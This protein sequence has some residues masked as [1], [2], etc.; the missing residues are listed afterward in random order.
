M[1]KTKSTIFPLQYRKNNGNIYIVD[2][3]SILSEII[4]K[5]PLRENAPQTE[6]EETVVDLESTEIITEDLSIDLNIA[7]QDEYMYDYEEYILPILDRSNLEEYINENYDILI[8]FA[9]QH[10]DKLFIDTLRSERSLAFETIDRYQLA[11]VFET[12]TDIQKEELKKY[13]E[14]WLNVTKTRIVPEKLSWFK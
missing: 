12:L 1:I 3:S 10:D 4:K 6:L 9:K 8:D 11:L 13:R 5:E 7:E 14:D 2:K